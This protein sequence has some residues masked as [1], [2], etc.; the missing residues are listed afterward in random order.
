MKR[1]KFIGLLGG[2]AAW[3]LIARAQQP[4]QMRRVGVLMNLAPD[5]AEGQARLKVFQ[6]GLQD[7]GWIEGHNVHV[8]TCWGAGKAEQYR[9]CAAELVALAP[10]VILAGSGATLPALV[11]TTRSVP[12]VFVQVVD[13]VAGGYVASL[14]KPG[15]NLTGFTQFELNIGGKWLEL[16][17]Q[18]APRV[19][20]V[21]VLRDPDI[22]EG[23]AQFATI[24]S[25][26]PSFGVEL[27]TVGVRDPSEIE[28]GVTAFARDP[29]GGLIVTA[30]AYT[31]VHHNLIVA[32][33]A[34]RRL[35]AVYPF[36]YHVISGGLLSYGPNPRDPYRQA[37]AYVDRVLKGEKPGDLPVQQSTKVELVINAKTAKSLGLEVP[38]TLLALA[39]EVIE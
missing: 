16:L 38:P 35:P 31:A 29:D 23:L 21:A 39:D 34:R 26:A 22:V 11:Q 8:D 4:G 32:L 17:K 25:V 1:R 12:I 24:Q 2:V 7:Q 9:A 37:A 28:G 13:P 36:R 6:Q 19:T 15:G 18:L 27:I 20:R 10:E 14:A 33:A 3:P 30:S 5:D